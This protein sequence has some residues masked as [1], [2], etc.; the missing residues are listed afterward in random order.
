MKLRIKFIVPSFLKRIIFAKTALLVYRKL[1]ISH[2]LTAFVAMI[3][4]SLPLPSV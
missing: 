1:L 2:F 3:M 4:G